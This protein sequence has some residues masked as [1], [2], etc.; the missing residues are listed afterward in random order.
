[1]ILQKYKIY[2]V[3]F[4]IIFF[5]SLS[6][7]PTIYDLSFANKLY[8]QN[9]EFV[10]EHN[11]YWPDFNLYLSKIR[12]GWEGRFLAK[13][14]YSSEPHQGSLIQIFY[15]NLGHAGKILGLDPN[16]SY[17]LGRLILTPTVLLVIFLLCQYIFKNTLWQILGFILVVM[18]GSF[19]RFITDQAGQ[20]TV[21]RYMEWW[22]NIDSLQ[23]IAFIPHILFGQ[24]VSFGLLYIL[25]K[26]DWKVSWKGVAVY[27]GVGNILGLVFPPSLLTLNATVILV[28]IINIIKTRNVKIGSLLLFAVALSL[29]SQ[30]YIW[31]LTKEIPWIALVNVH[32][33]N[34][35]LVP[36]NE[37]LLALG[38]IVILAVIGIIIALIKKE[39][40]VRPLILWLI[41]TYGF[42]I[43]FTHY[44]EQSP[45]RF[46]QTG[47][48]IPLGILGTY[49]LFQ[50]KKIIN[51]T[52]VYIFI[53]LYIVE[54][55]FIMKLSWDWQELFISVR[56]KANIPAVPY[57]PQTLHPL[58]NWM[59][60]I[61]WIGTNTNKNDVVLAEFS[62]GNY[63]PAYTGNTVYLGQ[64]NTYDYDKKYALLQKFFRGEMT[65]NEAQ[66]F[67]KTG[68]IRYVFFGPQEKEEMH[69]KN[70]EDYYVF[71]KPIYKNDNVTIY[72]WY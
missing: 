39:K 72:S 43:L 67:L 11:Y 6:F 40:N 7:L 33:I 17:Q 19:P 20:M 50:S 55:I 44:K 23:R 24:A 58:K 25:M 27:A 47:V 28:V 29:P 62:A 34:H 26:K 48:H 13:E 64:V 68:N 4:L 57:P 12:Q 3:S 18:S 69:G 1:M 32:R 53:T 35:M 66:E 46:T 71:F 5:T 52:I 14:V 63:I 21:Q 30:I 42:T 56:A 65:W 22:S 70:L 8:D 41:V 59:T 51:K 9:R 10:L 15:V 16:F 49:A 45:L 36:F 31:T 60:A 2:I 38:P 61:R 37:Y 54:N